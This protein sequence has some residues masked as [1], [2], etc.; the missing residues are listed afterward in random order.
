MLSFCLWA[1]ALSLLQKKG[2]FCILRSAAYLQRKDTVPS[3]FS[4][5][6]V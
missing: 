1:F 2:V 5:Y 6:L 3:S 4:I